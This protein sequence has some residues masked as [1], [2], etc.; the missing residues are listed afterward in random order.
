[1]TV[2]RRRAREIAHA[3]LSRGDARGWF[4]DL[5]GRAE[6]GSAVI[7][8]TD[9]TPNP[10]LVRWLRRCQPKGTG[11]TALV[12][13]CGLGDDAEELCRLGFETTAFD[14]SATAVGWCQRRFP[15]ST[16]NYRVAD[17]FEPPPAWDGYF[18]FVLEAYTLQ[19]LPPH[20]RV[21]AITRMAA[22]TAP[23]GTLLAIARGRTADESEGRMPWPLLRSEFDAFPRAGLEQVTFEEYMDDEDPP[24]RRFRIEYHRS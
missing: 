21:A 20:L 5:Y 24:V 12:I 2:S 10:N 4:E 3:Y 16:V 18:D 23:G 1:M 9:M 6:K 17:L 22:F 8:W 14:I 15:A 13:G 11:K 19:V 7:P